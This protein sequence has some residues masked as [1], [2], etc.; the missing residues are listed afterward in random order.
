M[1]SQI[2][3]YPIPNNLL[4]DL[5]DKIC[6]KNNK[7]YI[8]NSDSYKKGVFNEEIQKFFEL[9]KPY[10]FISKRKY[11]DKKLCYNSFAT[12]LRQICNFNKIIYTSQIIYNNSSYNIVYYV[13]FPTS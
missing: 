5:L 3:K 2:F 9:C 7:H 4:F 8:F 1:I 10:Y 13:Y 12:I 6:L 11:L